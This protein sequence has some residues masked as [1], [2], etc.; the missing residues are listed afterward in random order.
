MLDKVKME[1]DYKQYQ[2]SIKA[3]VDTISDKD[4][5]LEVLEKYAYEYAFMNAVHRRMPEM[6]RLSK[7]WGSD[8][9]YRNLGEIFSALNSNEINIYEYLP[10]VWD[11][12]MMR[13]Y[14][15][16]G[17]WKVL[18]PI[19]TS[20]DKDYSEIKYETPE[21]VNHLNELNTKIRE[22]VEACL[23][24]KI[25]EFVLAN[26]GKSESIAWKVLNECSEMYAIA[27]DL[28]NTDGWQYMRGISGI[29]KFD[30]SGYP[31]PKK[32]YL[33][34]S[35]ALANNAE[36][37]FNGLVSSMTADETY[38]SVLADNILGELMYAPELVNKRR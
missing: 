20:L 23:E 9:R 1:A 13:G 38:D 4:K 19:L 34:G 26:S 14:R 18:H 35:E 7:I 2:D 10:Q 36:E 24:A 22:S 8:T 32:Y 15:K 21:E 25:N 33:S 16:W 28:I 11:A 30:T 17:T 31:M 12:D 3:K 5:V 6:I 29:V 27:R 37:V